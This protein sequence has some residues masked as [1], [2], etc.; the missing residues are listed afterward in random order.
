MVPMVNLKVFCQCLFTY[1][2][3]IFW[4][5]LLTKLRNAIFFVLF[6]GRELTT[7]TGVGHYCGTLCTWL[8]LCMGVDIL[9]LQA[10]MLWSV[11]VVCDGELFF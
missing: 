7:V 5:T 8:I 2:T 3:P 1:T 6:K 11:S 9:Y 10:D 4:N